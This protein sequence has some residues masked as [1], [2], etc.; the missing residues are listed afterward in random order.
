MESRIGKDGSFAQMGD[1]VEVVKGRKF[2]IGMRMVVA[3]FQDG[4]CYWQSSPNSGRYACA[5]N[6]REIVFMDEGFVLNSI[7]D[8]NV[9]IVAVRGEG[10]QS[11]FENVSSFR[12]DRY[13]DMVLSKG[14]KASD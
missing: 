13:G 5:C 14:I 7:N 12:Y 2:P 3:D 1:M 6:G 10:D 9:R 4:Y 8:R 11:V